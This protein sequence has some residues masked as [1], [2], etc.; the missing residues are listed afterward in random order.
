MA[1]RQPAAS[2]PH[3][4]GAGRARSAR[5]TQF[6]GRCYRGRWL[7]ECHKGTNPQRNRAKSA[8]A[9]CHCIA[10]KAKAPAPRSLLAARHTRLRPFQVLVALI[11]WVTRRPPPR[12]LLSLR[13]AATAA[14][15]HA[16]ASQNF[17]C[18]PAGAATPLAVTST[19]IISAPRSHRNQ[20]RPAASRTLPTKPRWTRRRRRL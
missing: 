3:T 11:G 16:R 4:A 10:P 7:N 19:G 13:P 2:E 5:N 9:R 15:P 12:R 6:A 17:P 1:G 20:T 14:A 18:L 8:R